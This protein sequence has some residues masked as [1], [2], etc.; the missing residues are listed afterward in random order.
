MFSIS[1][2]L[3][4][5]NNLRHYHPL[6]VFPQFRGYT[7]EGS[8][9]RADMSK[10]Q[11][12]S[13]TGLAALH[14]PTGR[15]LF[16]E[17]RLDVYTPSWE[18]SVLG[19]I[20]DSLLAALHDVGLAHM[21]DAF[22]ASVQAQSSVDLSSLE[23]RILASGNDLV[24]KSLEQWIYPGKDLKFKGISLDS[25][26]DQMAREGQSG[27]D[28]IEKTQ[29]ALQDLVKY[30]TRTLIAYLKRRRRAGMFAEL[31]LRQRGRWMA[32][33]KATLARL[34]AEFQLDKHPEEA[35]T[36]GLSANI[37][38]DFLYAVTLLGD[39][40]TGKYYNFYESVA[41]G[42]AIYAEHVL[43]KRINTAAILA[44]DLDLYAGKLRSHDVKVIHPTNEQRQLWVTRRDFA[45]RI[46]RAA[47]APPHPTSHEPC[48]ACHYRSHCWVDGTPGGVPITPPAP[49]KK[50]KPG[51]EP[52]ANPN[53]KPV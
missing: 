32:E 16:L 46:I 19:N 22:E 7:G 44:I 53:V 48:H 50:G 15:D 33:A 3:G 30:E 37:K 31:V 5:P 25:F 34:Q 14:C 51:Q 6:P 8:Q 1:I 17:K 35:R 28:L 40:K 49:V 42:Y 45:L 36:F 4:A 13:I 21:E 10:G 11:V 20:V 52:A 26:A 2:E 24:H 29:E 27:P 38:P 47:S 39:I 43:H 41:T 18:R 23:T 9:V 12:V